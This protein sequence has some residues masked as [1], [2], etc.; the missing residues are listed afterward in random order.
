MSPR[1]SARERTQSALFIASCQR[2]LEV[3]E[4]EDVRR[5][6]LP[7]TA[8]SDA[9]IVVRAREVGV[10]IVTANSEDYEE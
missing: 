4:L 3:Q 10:M 5:Q 9:E 7:R 1:L 2:F 8:A 6:D